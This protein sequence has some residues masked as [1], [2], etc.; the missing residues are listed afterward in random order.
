M[1]ITGL[2]LKKIIFFFILSLLLVLIGTLGY[3]VIEHWSF[4]ES[5]YMTIITLSTVGFEEVH[6]LTPKGEVFTIC[7]IFMG[8]G[9][10]AYTIGSVAQ[11]MV[12][13]HI[14]KMLERRACK[15]RLTN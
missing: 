15:K 13:G 5:L 12:E 14:K 1:D 10:V 4:L 3:M 6:Q 8:I 2:E 7:L 11:F 9:V